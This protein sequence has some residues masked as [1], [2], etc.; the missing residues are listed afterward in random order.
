[1][2][3]AFDHVAVA[4]YITLNSPVSIA[5][6]GRIASTTVTV[7]NV[8]ATPCAYSVAY[9]AANATVADLCAGS[10]RVSTD[11]TWTIQP[12]LRLP[13][14]WINVSFNPFSLL[15]FDTLLLLNSCMYRMFTGVFFSTP[16]L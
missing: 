8:S 16:D 2:W 3:H 10:P 11:F 12:V 4:E 13:V 14:R 6:D 1:M 5:L 15:T 9:I 7:S